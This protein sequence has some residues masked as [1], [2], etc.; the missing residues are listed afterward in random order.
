MTAKPGHTQGIITALPRPKNTSSTSLR[1]LLAV[2]AALMFSTFTAV[3]QV[4]SGTIVGTVTDPSGAF[5]PQVK[6]EAKTVEPGVV[7]GTPPPGAGEHR[8]GGLVAGTYTVTASGAGF[9]NSS[10]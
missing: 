6:V 5:L 2:F 1:Y 8:S 9:T 7:G 3:A 10:R 4:S